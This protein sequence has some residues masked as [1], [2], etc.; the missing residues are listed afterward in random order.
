MKK[1][2]PVKRKGIMYHFIEKVDAEKEELKQTSGI[3]GFEKKGDGGCSCYNASWTH[4]CQKHR[5]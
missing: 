1:N 4:G 3:E 2:P 5:R